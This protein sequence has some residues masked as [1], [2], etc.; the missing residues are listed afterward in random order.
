MVVMPMH[1][2]NRLIRATS[3]L[4]GKADL[5]LFSLFDNLISVDIS[6]FC[7]RKSKDGEADC[8]CG[9]NTTRGN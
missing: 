4:T 2:L 7:S 6:E 9:W 3:N 8:C 5:A 1:S